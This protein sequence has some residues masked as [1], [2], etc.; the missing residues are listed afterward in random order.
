MRLAR[1]RWSEYTSGMRGIQRACASDVEERELRT[2][3]EQ[4]GLGVDD[5]RAPI[6]GIPVRV[7]L[8]IDEVR[9]IGTIA[10]TLQVDSSHIL[11]AW[12]RSRLH[13]GA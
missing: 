5:M 7:R 8:S 3:A 12:I 10:H 2:F 4:L 13:E 9:E 11:R 1:P 6:D